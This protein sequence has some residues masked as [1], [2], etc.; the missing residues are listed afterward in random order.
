MFATAAAD[1]QTDYQMTCPQ[2]RPSADLVTPISDGVVGFYVPR[3][4]LATGTPR[5]GPYPANGVT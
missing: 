1:Y 2:T 4:R 5:A 3:G